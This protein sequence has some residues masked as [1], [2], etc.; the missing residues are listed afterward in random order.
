M[1]VSNVESPAITLGGTGNAILKPER[2]Q[3]LE[4]G[5]D[6]TAFGNRVA[7]E[8]TAYRKVTDDAL[9]NRRLAPSLG[10]TLTRVENL[11]QVRNAGVEGLLTLVPLSRDAVRWESSISASHNKNKLVRLGEGIT[12]VIFGANSVQ[13][14]RGGFPAGGFFQRTFTYG[15]LNGDGLISRVNCPTVAGRANPQVPGGPACEITL[16]DSVQYLGTPIA[17][18]QI[19]FNNTVS[20][21]IVRLSALLDM[22]KGAKQFNFTRGFRCAEFLNCRDIQDRN[23]PLDAQAN[24]VAALMGTQAGYIEEADFV[25]LRE[26]ALTLSLPK[27][28]AASLRSEALSV[29][30]AGRNLKTWTDYTG[31]DPE[32][33]SSSGAN[34]TT[35]DFLAQPPVRVYT[36]RLNANF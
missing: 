17:P 4:G 30:F 2:T 7:L 34:F 23:A 11:G 31:F 33:N 21:G 18:T 27:S 20:L 3:E 25:K 29:T 15:D 14:F 28:L 26:V 36:V 35:T 1:T 10:A 6:L 9:I 22:R 13:Q 32:V 16:S 24:A 19:A 5:F 8:F 12:P